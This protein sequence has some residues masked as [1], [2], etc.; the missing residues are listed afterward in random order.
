MKRGNDITNK[1][2]N[3]EELNATE[4]NFSMYLIVTM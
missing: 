1:M 3:M 4:Q 2:I